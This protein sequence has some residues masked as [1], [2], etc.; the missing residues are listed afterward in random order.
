MQCPEPV[1]SVKTLGAIEFVY[2]VPSFPSVIWNR[3]IRHPWYSWT[4]IYIMQNLASTR[5]SPIELKH[6]DS[7]RDLDDLSSGTQYSVA[8][9]CVPAP[10]LF[11]H[12]E[13]HSVYS[14]YTIIP[15]A[16]AVVQSYWLIL[17][18]PVPCRIAD[19]QSS[20]RSHKESSGSVSDASIESI[21]ESIIRSHP[22]RPFK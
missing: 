18:S 8:G 15:S 7:H 12:I 3:T 10:S 5:V 11:K 4:S 9:L 2:A 20:C 1:S 19:M 22:F 13:T 21:H 14:L 16:T 6:L 17:S